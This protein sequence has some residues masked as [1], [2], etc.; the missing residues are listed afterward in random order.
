MYENIRKDFDINEKMVVDSILT[1]TTKNFLLKG[2]S[3]KG[4]TIIL[5]SITKKLASRSLFKYIP[6]V[7]QATAVCVGYK[8][9][10]EAGEEYIIACY[11]AA[12]ENMLRRLNAK[13]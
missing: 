6:L 2:M 7:G 1:I 9:V 4:I 10:K 11:Q 12:Q 5:K 3:K 8:I 13:K